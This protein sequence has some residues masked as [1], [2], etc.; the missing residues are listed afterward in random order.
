[1]KDKSILNKIVLNCITINEL[2]DNNLI[3]KKKKTQNQ[4]Q[5]N[6]II[7]RWCD[8][9]TSGNV[10]KFA[11]R[12]KKGNINISKLRFLLSSYK[13]KRIFLI[14][15]PWVKN[16]KWV[17]NALK[18]KKKVKTSLLKN[19]SYKKY[20][21]EDIYYQLAFESYNKLKNEFDLKNI[22]S[23][24][25]KKNLIDN[26]LSQLSTISQKLLYDY[27]LIY[28][29]NK[30]KDTTNDKKFF[31]NTFVNYFK[32]S[33]VEEVF[34]EYPILLRI[35]SSITNQWITSNKLFLKRFILDK[36][37]IEKKFLFEIKKI[38]RI[39]TDLS[40][41]HNLGQSVYKIHFTSKN[42][43]FYKPKDLRADLFIENLLAKLNKANPPQKL[44]IPKFILKEKYGWVENISHE[45]CKKKNDFN[46]YF[47]KAGSW[48]ALLHLLSSTDFH[49]ENII[50]SKEW[51]IPIDFETILQPDGNIVNDNKT[52]SSSFKKALNFINE[53]VNSVGM[54]PSYALFEDNIKAYDNSGLR[55]GRPSYYG[56]IWKNINQDSMNIKKGVILEKAYMNM[57]Y[58]KSYR[59]NL[60]EYINPLI[61]GFENYLS[62]ILKI[63]KKYGV[64]FFFKKTSNLNVRYLLRPTKFYYLLM[65]R[66]KNFEN[67]KNGFVWSIESDFVTRFT[68]L[69]SKKYFN[70]NIHKIEREALLNF[71]IPYIK[72]SHLQKNK[73]T[74][75]SCGIKRSILK[76]K[77]LSENKIK[78][79]SSIIRET[80]ALINKRDVKENQKITKYLKNFKS[81][82]NKNKKNLVKEV[83]SIY[84]KLIKTA[85]KSKKDLSWVAVNWLGESEVGQL[86]TM[87]PT[88]YNGSL[89][90]AVFIGA[91]SKIF[92]NKK[93]KDQSYQIVKPIIKKIYSIES[94][95]MLKLI[96]I[97]GYTGAG[98][99]IYGFAVLY[100]LT[101]NKV[102][103]KC[104]LKITS[105]INDDLIKKDNNLDLLDGVS[106]MILALIYL[107][108]FNKDKNIRSLAIKC[109][110]YLIKQPRIK[111][112]YF[113]SWKG[114]KINT[115]LPLTGISH[116]AS[117]FALALIKLSKISNNKKF[118]KYG[119]DCI[120]YENSVYSIKKKNWPD[121]RNVKG[122]WPCQWCHGAV[123]VGLSR[124]DL[125]NNNI[126]LRVD[127]KKAINSA[128]V[129]WPNSKDTICCGT[130][131]S[132]IFMNRI[133]NIYNNKK[134][135]NLSIEW[136]S[137]VINLAEKTGDYRLG[138]NYKF[139]P[140]LF[141]GLSGVG[142][143]ILRMLNNKLPKIETLS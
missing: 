40:D 76:I 63:R 75:Y 25:A 121:F 134:F 115:K 1:M 126:N 33:K 30:C 49:A 37:R 65:E 60:G 137:S 81:V 103:L 119:V 107:Y 85:F 106:G 27:F 64:N 71:N 58:Y 69:N 62:F 34:L 116:G 66:L 31:Y 117:G 42:I 3:I 123:G 4:D 77:K 21:F 91:Y 57:P 52:F 10:K 55:G 15:T 110:E 113:S 87:E 41:L 93:A 132:I 47:N 104:A 138:A 97:G 118:Y 94:M 68:D 44:I 29:K 38:Y 26:L 102:F 142:Y 78:M 92:R 89:G 112:N 45:H 18:N 131:G 143:T 32:E 111:Y 109:G 6:K 50:A 14:K 99:L 120:K 88:L 67:M 80:S 82:K 101:K 140:G 12:I 46:T 43:L 130:M 13:I 83:K 24:N 136:I 100:N 70:W 51:P 73:N 54:L 59:P 122:K 17:L 16:L 11:K 98:S 79:Q 124:L 96:G 141:L 133:S 23:E 128:I 56:D 48:L 61:N 7:E 36:Q 108:N 114:K 135:K 39:E 84:Q 139:N 22:L 86:N 125:L 129:N 19:K 74:K 8:I 105:L 95:R 35:I 20:P 72:V 28:K 9:S 5:V 2:F 127:L 53:S 90:I